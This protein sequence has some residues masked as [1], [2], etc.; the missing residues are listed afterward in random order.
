MRF[1]RF[2]IYFVRWGLTRLIPT[3][4]TESQCKSQPA[5]RAAF[6]IYLRLQKQSF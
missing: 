5:A 3:F 6:L 2:F 1:D 4:L